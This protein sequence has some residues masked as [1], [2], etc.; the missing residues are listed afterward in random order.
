MGSCLSNAG[1]PAD[2]ECVIQQINDCEV[3]GVTAAKTS[4]ACEDHPKLVTCHD[5]KREDNND[6][7]SARAAGQQ[8]AFCVLRMTENVLSVYKIAEELGQG[9]VAS[10]HRHIHVNLLFQMFGCVHKVLLSIN[11]ALLQQFG[12]VSIAIHKKTGERF[13]IKSLSKRKSN[14]PINKFCKD[15]RNEVC[16]YGFSSLGY[17]PHRPHGM[18]SYRI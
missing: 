15:V 17:L 12:R 14:A 8:S 18:I 7:R 16:S 5:V 1:K 13:A 3:I 4:S 6:D 9:Q 10:P 2:E 11:L